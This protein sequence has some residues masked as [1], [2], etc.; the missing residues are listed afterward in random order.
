MI[1]ASVW[2]AL[3]NAVSVSSPA[4][5]GRL[6]AETMPVVTVPVSPSGAPIA[7]TG[8]P[9]RTE[10]ESPSASGTSPST[11]TLM[12]ARSYSAVRP[13]IVAVASRPSEN[14]T[15]SAP[16]SASAPATTWLLVSR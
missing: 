8:S 11:S 1:A 3:M 2:M 7:T 6:S 16:P 15:T 5:T 13:T 12:T 14:V 4:D 10:S 9:T